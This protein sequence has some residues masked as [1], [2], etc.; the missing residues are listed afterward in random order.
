MSMKDNVKAV[1]AMWLMNCPLPKAIRWIK[2]R[3]TT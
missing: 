1:Y 2:T 3:L